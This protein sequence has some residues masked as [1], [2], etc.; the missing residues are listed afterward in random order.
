MAKPKRTKERRASLHERLAV[1]RVRATEERIAQLG[2][3]EAEALREASWRAARAVAMA[4]KA[5]PKQQKAGEA[6][7]NQGKVDWE[8]VRKRFVEWRNSGKYKHRSEACRRLADEFKKQAR[9]GKLS[10]ESVRIHTRDI[11]WR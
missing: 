10:P 11:A 9:N 5:R 7:L 6:R 2:E 4:E 8:E 3:E 1:T